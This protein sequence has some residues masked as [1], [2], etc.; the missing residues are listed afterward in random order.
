[1]IKNPYSIY[2]KVYR[3][4]VEEYG[5]AGPASQFGSM[6]A[7]SADAGNG[8]GMFGTYPQDGGEPLPDEQ[9]GYG[10]GEHDDARMPTGLYAIKDGKKKK[11]ESQFPGLEIK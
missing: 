7:Q 1:M 2:K 6:G 5:G 3:Q 9:P 11:P 10:G 8:G 4:M